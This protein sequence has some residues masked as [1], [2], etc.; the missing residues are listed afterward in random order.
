VSR[1][2]YAIVDLARIAAH[3]LEPVAFAE[4]V[5]VAR[6]A[7]L[8]VRAKDVPARELLSLLRA[9]GAK[10]R[11]A[12]VPIVANDRADLAVLAGAD[13]VHV[14]QGDL[15]I[16]R[17]HRLAP[18]LGVGVSTHSIG[19]LT[20][21]LDARSDYVAYGPVYPTT[22]KQA[23]DPCV[24]LAGLAAASALAA[25]AGI[26]LVAIGGVTLAR[27]PELRRWAHA[28]AVIEALLPT[29][30][31]APYEE[32]TRR[33]MELHAALGGEHPGPRVARA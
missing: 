24:G 22:S 6:P 5:L 19:E 8:Q 21:A 12:G 26:P 15:P 14:G 33:A 13:F 4:A 17:V 25:Q 2:L 32:V 7:A 1:G 20:R 16:E 10:C 18:T 3:G 29:E 31:T 27:A 11:R 28:A 23:P 9:I 30:S